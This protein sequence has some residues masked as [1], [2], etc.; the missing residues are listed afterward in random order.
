MCK[1]LR[2]FTVK[3]N[4]IPANAECLNAPEL[5]SCSVAHGPMFAKLGTHLVHRL[6]H[7][8]QPYSSSCS[9]AIRFDFA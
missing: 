4:P 9:R 8:A 1:L 7:C 3:S 2:R 6:V 5:I